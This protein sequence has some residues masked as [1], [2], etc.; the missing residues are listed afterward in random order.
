MPA[1]IGAEKDVPPA[2]DHVLGSPE[3]AAPPLT[4]SD[5]QNT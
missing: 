4:V 1:K 3:H 2:P 5:Q